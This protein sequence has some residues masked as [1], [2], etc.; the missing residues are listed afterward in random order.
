MRRKRDDQRF[1]NGHKTCQNEIGVF[2]MFST[3]P[4]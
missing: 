3:I 2:L 4:E 1:K